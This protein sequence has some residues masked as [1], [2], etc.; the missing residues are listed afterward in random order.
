MASLGAT[1][2]AS[3]GAQMADRSALPPGGAFDPEQGEDE[4]QH[5]RRDLSRPAEISLREPCGVDSQRQCAH[6]EEAG[7]ADVVDAF[8]QCQAYTNRDGRTGQRQRHAAEGAPGRLAQRAR[9]FHLHAGL[10]SRCDKKLPFALTNLTLSGR[11]R[12]AGVLRAG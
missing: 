12:C 5:H 9:H 2:D 8:H 1:Y 3:Q 6:A 11:I 10:A 7:G 4:D